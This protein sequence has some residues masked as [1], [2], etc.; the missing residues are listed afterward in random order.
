MG[1]WLREL[2]TEVVQIQAPCLVREYSQAPQMNGH[3]SANP[4]LEAAA[5][6]RE[7]RIAAAPTQPR[8]LLT[9]LC[10][11][12]RTYSQSALELSLT[13]LL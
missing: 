13:R 5:R 6:L 4:V 11:C 12:R 10:C 1:P 8:G 2:V 3:V 7:L 9:P